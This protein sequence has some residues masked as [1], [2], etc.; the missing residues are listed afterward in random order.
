MIESKVQSLY[1]TMIKNIKTEYIPN[2]T[3]DQMRT[4]IQYL[5][6]VYLLLFLDENDLKH[7]KDEELS[8]DER[9]NLR[10]KLNLLSDVLIDAEVKNCYFSTREELLIFLNESE[11]DKYLKLYEYNKGYIY[12]HQALA[13][14]ANKLKKWYLY[15]GNVEIISKDNCELLI[16]TL[17]DSVYNM[18]CEH[19][20]VVV[21]HLPKVYEAL[22]NFSSENIAD[23][24]QYLSYSARRIVE[25]KKEVFN[26][27]IVYFKLDN[28]LIDLTTIL[29]NMEYIVGHMFT[30]KFMLDEYG[31]MSD[32][33]IKKLSD[34]AYSIIKNI[35]SMSIILNND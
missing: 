27:V 14:K 8:K 21:K 10:L 16:E 19:R 9:I 18:S 13:N 17:K 1:R 33:S 34:S 35:Y 31:N 4:Y 11:E 28:D 3:A 6:Q 32:A 23:Y 30:I 7:K 12:L 24:S 5:N 15:D 29:N 20:K 22:S 25:A 2:L 26:R